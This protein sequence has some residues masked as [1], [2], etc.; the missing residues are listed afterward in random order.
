MIGNSDEIDLECPWI[1]LKAFT[2]ETRSLFFG[3]KRE[4]DE[5]CERVR[6][7][8]LTILFG[9]SGH[10]KSSLLGAGLL[11]SLDGE[12]FFPI[13]IKLQFLTSESNR[14]MRSLVDQVKLQIGGALENVGRVDLAESARESGGF[15]EM[16]NDERRGFL[17]DKAPK[18][19]LIFDQF[20]DLFTLGERSTD[21]RDRLLHELSD[22]IENRP[23][24]VLARRIEND[25]ELAERFDPFARPVK[26]VMALRED[27]L[28]KLDRWRPVMPSI[29]SNRMELR[30]LSGPQAL[31]AVYEPGR[32]G[33]MEI[34]SKHVAE[35]IVR[36]VA[37]VDEM[38][39]LSDIEAV[40]PLLSLYS[41]RLN[42]RRLDREK[43]NEASHNKE[44]TTIRAIDIEGKLDEILD[45][46]FEECF[47]GLP[48]GVRTFVEQKMVSP[49]LPSVREAPSIETVLADLST[50]LDPSAAEQ[51]IE[52]LRQRRLITQEEF[53]GVI[54]VIPTLGLWGLIAMIGTMLAGVFVMTRARD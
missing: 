8:P 44:R 10:G 7:N 52:K 14:K 53:E 9:S 6:R 18:I 2:P 12:G 34:V 4:I 33:G 19:V 3:R 24:S 15:W 31:L 28:S 38:T 11:P 17:E 23:S 54:R 49:G 1:G 50:F 30:P 42:K 25:Q 39:D 40:P 35:K 29:M 5:L 41:Q 37:G 48:K 27:Y 13:P 45:E 47:E 26:V 22:I 32:L 20:E 36:S 46:F 21:E 51:A 43:S 16:F